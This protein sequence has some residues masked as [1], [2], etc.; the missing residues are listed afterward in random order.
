LVWLAQS[1]NTTPLQEAVQAM[2]DEVSVD[3]LARVSAG[4]D[5]K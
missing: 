1:K 2:E 4:A 5:F 3:S